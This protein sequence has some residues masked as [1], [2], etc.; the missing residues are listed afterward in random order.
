VT[1]DF[2]AKPVSAYSNSI[3]VFVSLQFRQIVNRFE[4]IGSFQVINGSTNAI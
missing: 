3:K 1:N 4:R 2:E